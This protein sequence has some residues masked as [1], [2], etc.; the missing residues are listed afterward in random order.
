MANLPNFYLCIEYVYLIQFT[1]VVVLNRCEAPNCVS[2]CINHGDCTGGKFCRQGHCLNSC[3]TKRDCPSK[4]D[5]F[6]I[7]KNNKCFYVKMGC[8][9]DHHC[10]EGIGVH[11]FGVTRIIRKANK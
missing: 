2:K 10:P 8:L 9:G 6:A 3:Q 5:S 7:C 11:D 1:F 4:P